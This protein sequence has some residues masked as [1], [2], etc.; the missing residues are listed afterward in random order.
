[1]LLLVVLLLCL[2]FLKKAAVII[3]HLE[4]FVNTDNI[5]DGFLLKNS[6]WVLKNRRSCFIMLVACFD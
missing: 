1:M 4:E 6:H 5:F 2:L 3:A